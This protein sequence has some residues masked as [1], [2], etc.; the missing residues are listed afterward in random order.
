MDISGKMRGVQK[1][2]IYCFLVIFLL[3]QVSFEETHTEGEVKNE[4]A[5]PP[6]QDGQHAPPVQD[7][8][9]EAHKEVEE[10]KDGTNINIDPLKFAKDVGHIR[11]HLKSQY[12]FNDEQADQYLKEYDAQTQFFVMHDYDNNTKL[13]GLE[14]LKSMTHYHDDHEEGHHEESDKEPDNADTLIEFVD[15]ILKDQDYNNDGYIDYP[16]YINYYSKF[17][18]NK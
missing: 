18:K 3:V 10:N 4:Q 5:A 2:C 12:G 7:G 11:E 17:D 6:V 9:H 15:M 8:Q 14:L 16:E 13:D 1:K